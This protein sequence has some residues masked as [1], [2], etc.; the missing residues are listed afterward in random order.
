MTAVGTEMSAFVVVMWKV[1]EDFVTAAIRE[2]LDNRLGSVRSPAPCLPDRGRRL[3]PRDD[4]KG[5]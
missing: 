1:F 2:A 3:E 5:S 4:W